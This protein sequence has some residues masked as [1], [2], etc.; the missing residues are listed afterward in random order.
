YYYINIGDDV[1]LFASNSSASNNKKIN[2]EALAKMIGQ[3]EE[4]QK[5]FEDLKINK[6]VVM[7]PSL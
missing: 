1:D 3:M 7:D 2:K 4:R 6:P 5:K